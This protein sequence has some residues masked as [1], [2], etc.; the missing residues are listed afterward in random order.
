M[1][2]YRYFFKEI[3]LTTLSVATIVLVIASGSR[4]GAYLEDAA[5][6]WISK[7][8]LFLLLMYRLP[9]FLELILPISFFLG[10]I[11][12]YGR[13]YADSEMIILHACGMGQVRLMF[14]TLTMALLVMAITAFLTLWL[15]PFSESKVEKMYEVQRGKSE[16]AT[17]A[18][19]RFQT[20]RSGKRVT[21]TE[22]LDSEGGII[23]PF[24]NEYTKTNIYGPKEVNT[25]VADSGSSQ[26]DPQTGARFL[27]LKNG[28]RYTGEPGT[29]NYQ[30]VQ[31]EEYG[32]LVAME[33]VEKRARRRSAIATMELLETHTTRGM[34]EF[35]WRIS[36]I[37]LVP[38]VAAMAIPLSKVNPRQGRFT[39]LIP[40]LLLCFFYIVV[41]SAARSSLERGEFPAALGLWWVHAI[42]I[43][44]T[45]GL[46][47]FE[48]LIA[49]RP[50]ARKRIS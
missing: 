17:L 13:L 26:I 10:I 40:G 45:I 3:F 32:Q 31:Y 9:G 27:V 22:D 30:I 1:I 7:D 12:T 20:L 41:L 37:L 42:F 16:F 39:R 19:G 36:I 48:K 43:L 2:L 44:I 21:Y 5:A 25:I 24:I 38:I 6:G 14:I 28:F 4:F 15:K 47:N 11:L 33:E 23:K 34:A 49:L 29:A 35:H 46:Y 8:I 18:P 50:R